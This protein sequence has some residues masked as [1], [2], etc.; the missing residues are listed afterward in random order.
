MRKRRKKEYVAKQPAVRVQE[1]IRSRTHRIRHFCQI[2][3]R[4]SIGRQLSFRFR[5]SFSSHDHLMREISSA[6]L[7][8]TTNEVSIGAS[9]FKNN[10]AGDSVASLLVVRSG[11]ETFRHLDLH[12]A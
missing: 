6:R 4:K 11:R 10:W 5:C 3:L 9:L 8:T 1:A 12:L 7:G 2:T